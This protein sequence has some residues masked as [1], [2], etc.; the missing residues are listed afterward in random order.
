MK[1]AKVFL[2][3]GSGGVGKT[4]VSAA[5]GL[6]L[7]KQGYAVVVV[8]VDP[9]KR[10]ATALGIGEIGDDPKPVP[11]KAAGSLLAMMLD[12]KR[13]FDRL[14]E[15]H[16]PTKTQCDRILNNVLY[17]KMSDMMAGTQEYMA[18][19]RLYELY[20]QGKYDAIVVDTPPMQHA[21][22]FLEAPQRMMRMLNNSMLQLLLKPAMA[23]G[24][25]GLKFFEKGSRTI[26]KVFDKI[27]GFDFLQD[28]SE[29][30]LAFQ[31]L[32]AGFEERANQVNT[33]F[34]NP[35]CQFLAVCTTTA[36]SVS[37][38]ELFAGQLRN[39]GYALSSII[40]NRVYSGKV[41]SAE[42][43]VADK[44]AL[45]R[46]LGAEGAEVVAQNFYNYVPLIRRDKKAI[47]RMTTLVK[48]TV[49]SVPLFE[50]DVHDLESLE[51]IAE[52]LTALTQ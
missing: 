49:L 6:A 10:L 41:P 52:R 42:A 8:T 32:L 45:K 16:A 51:R 36:N 17:R 9:A 37:E 11:V 31:D 26:L 4:T 27:T 33:L 12:T 48:E 20:A 15:K 25:K 5:L 38:T 47:Q 39:Y 1:T 35:E 40:V 34:K 30:A 50:A 28:L 21:L 2:V 24:K 7:A 29:M 3:C 18:M 23:V 22:D 46:C 44:L 43:L 13:T 19:E 14:I